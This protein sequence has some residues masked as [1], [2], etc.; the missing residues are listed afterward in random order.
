MQLN[1]A[2]TR[3]FSEFNVSKT[4]TRM[5]VLTEKFHR[6]LFNLNIDELMPFEGQ[7]RK[8]FD[9]K[10]F[11]QLIILFNQVSNTNDNVNNSIVELYV[12]VCAI[13]ISIFQNSTKLNTFPW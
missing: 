13:G 2:K 7:A 11:I 3:D 12:G 1:K 4:N 9:D 8:I 6:E 10:I 5:S